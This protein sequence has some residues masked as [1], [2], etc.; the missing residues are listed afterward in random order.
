MSPPRKMLKWEEVVDYAFLADFDLL[1]DARADISQSLWSSPAARSAMDLH[2]KICHA[3]EEIFRLNIEVCRLVTYIHDEDNYLRMS[4][5]QLKNTNPGLAHQISIIYLSSPASAEPSA[6]VP[7]A[8]VPANK[9]ANYISACN[10]PY[11]VD[12]LEDLEEEEEEEEEV[13]DEIAEEASRRLQDVLFITQ[14]L[15]RLELSDHA[16]LE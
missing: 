8:R 1:R 12:T 4:E 6:S 9:H 16:D 11:P 13:E 10:P 5:E 15:S 2:F 3:Q 14:D 7:A